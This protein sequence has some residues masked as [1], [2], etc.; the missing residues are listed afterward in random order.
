M[1]ALAWKIQR[2]ID[3]G[4]VKDRAEVARRLVMTRARVTQLLDLT[5][6]APEVQEHMLAEGVP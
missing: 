1:L 2:A 6:L 5:L 4:Q 3:R